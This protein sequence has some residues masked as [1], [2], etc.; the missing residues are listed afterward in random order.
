MVCI[1]LSDDGQRVLSGSLNKT[2]RVWDAESSEQV[3]HLIIGD[4]DWVQCVV[5]SN[6]GRLVVSG[7]DDNTVRVWDV[8]S[9]QDGS[10]LGL[11]L[12]AENK[13]KEKEMSYSHLYIEWPEQLLNLVF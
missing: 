3:G 2:I 9:S 6:D 5:L 8:K 11:R 13:W 12:L 10:C 1:A 7:S 4:E